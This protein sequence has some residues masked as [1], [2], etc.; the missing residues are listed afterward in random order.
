MGVIDNIIWSLRHCRKRLFESILIVFA[1]GLGVAVIVSIL[2]LIVYFRAQVYSSYDDEW[3][4]TFRIYSAANFSMSTGQEP[5]LRAVQERPQEPLQ[6]TLSELK[7]LQESLPSGMHVF[8]ELRSAFPSPLLPKP[9]SEADTDS[10]YE[11]IGPVGLSSQGVTRIV[12]TQS[13]AVTTGVPVNA[14]EMSLT[15]NGAEEDL[16]SV[17]PNQIDA[18]T[19][20]L[21]AMVEVVE[22]EVVESEQQTE[23]DVVMESKSMMIQDLWSLR[24][25]YEYIDI[26]GTTLSYFDFKE[27]QLAKGSLFVE[28]DIIN[29]NRVIVLSD[30]LAGRIFGETDPIGQNIPIHVLA[31]QEQEISFTVIGVLAPVEEEEELYSYPGMNRYLAFA[32]FTAMPYHAVSQDQEVIL[33]SFIVGVEKGTDLAQASEIIQAEIKQRYG[34]LAVVSNSYITMTSIEQSNYAIYI[35]VAIFASLGLIIAVIN[36]LNLMLARVLRRTKSVGLSMALGSTKSAVFGQFLLEA[37]LL[38]L[39]GAVVGTGLSFVLLKE[40]VS[41]LIM[42]EVP[43]GITGIAAGCGLG[44]LV[45]LLFG[46]YPAYQGAIINPV[47]AL[48]NE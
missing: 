35:I 48:R 22:I 21:D 6:V 17:A 41:K 43:L 13:A 39:T 34:D 26:I 47:D 20:S 36:I 16:G 30:Q 9:E 2:V 19:G 42:T 7:A 23:S 28:D 10:Q 27:Y 5:I 25:Q 24:T 45:S 33:N 4:R 14:V 15:H 29:G 18:G 3:I 37:V 8:A 44:L 11:F 40:V 46:V 31:G 38:G 32:P 12:S 1:I